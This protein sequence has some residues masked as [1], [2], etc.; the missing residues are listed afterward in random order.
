MLQPKSIMRAA[1]PK[2]T[3]A[4]DSVLLAK[5]DYIDKVLR[6]SRLDLIQETQPKKKKGGNAS[7]ESI[8]PPKR[9]ILFVAKSFPEW[10]ESIVEFLRRLTVTVCVLEWISV[11]DI[12]F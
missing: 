8:I 9:L 7:Q 2:V 6:E 5:R 12:L 4:V 10:Q 1:W 11:I 3:K